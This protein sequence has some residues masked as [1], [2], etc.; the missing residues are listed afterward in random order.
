MSSP[1]YGS[2]R[3]K[4]SNSVTPNAYTSDAGDDGRP[5][6]NSGAIQKG[7]PA[8]PSDRRF[9]ESPKSATCPGEEGTQAGEEDEEGR[10]NE[11]GGERGRAI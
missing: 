10:N 11:R 9:W 7:V 5:S 3:V 8:I 6:S 4:T 2:L 1:A